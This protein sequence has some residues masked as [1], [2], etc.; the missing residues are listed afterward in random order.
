MTTQDAVQALKE[1]HHATWAAGDYAAV[2]RL[3]EEVAELAV[4]AAGVSAGMD[5]LD[6]ATGTGNA[7][8]VAAQRGARVTGLDLTPELLETARRRAT[9]L[10]VE[11]EWVEGDAEA[12]PFEDASFDRVLSVF[13]VM[14]APRHEVAAAELARVLRPDGELVLCTWTS[15]H[16]VAETFGIVGRRMPPPPDFAQPPVRWGD[17]DH[18]RELL[19]PHGIEPSFERRTVRIPFENGEVQTAFF[20]DRFGPVVLARQVL[21]P[22]VWQEMRRELVELV[23]RYHDGEATP[24]DYW[25]ITGRR[26][27]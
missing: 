4:D 7:A 21:D 9:E 27:G 23:D 1:R 19:A 24:Q 15:D 18:V 20:E 14:F 5:V 12:L 17:P 22:R 26:A 6:V 25:L 10:G 11:V 16:L 3:I 13:G 8:L 2:A